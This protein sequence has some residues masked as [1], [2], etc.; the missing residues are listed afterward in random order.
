ML[1]IQANDDGHPVLK[2]SKEGATVVEVDAERWKEILA[3]G[4]LSGQD[5]VPIEPAKLFE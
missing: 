4:D 5:I 2:E 1:F 3:E